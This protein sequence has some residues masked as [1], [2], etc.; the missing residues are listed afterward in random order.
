MR[1]VALVVA[2][3]AFTA[4][5]VTV[6]VDDGVLGFLT[7]AARRPWAMQML[8][9]LGIMLT[10]FSI[11]LRHDSRSLGLPT[12]PYIVLALT[13]GSMGVLTYLIHREV[14][15]RRRTAGAPVVP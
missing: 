2:F 7:L 13:M 1:L 14:R 8:L 9:D 15:I 3:V 6:M 10:L 4:Y 5:T 11:W 12:W